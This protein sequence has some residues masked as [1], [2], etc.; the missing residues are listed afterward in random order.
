MVLYLIGLGLDKKS[1]S[2]DALHVLKGCKMVYLEG[3]TVDFPY[4]MGGLREALEIDFMILQRGEVESEKLI[5]EA[6]K[7]DIALLVYGDAL[8]ATTHSSLLEQCKEQRVEFKVFPNASIFT[9]VAATGLSLYKFGKVSSLPDWKQ[10]THKPASFITYLKENKKIKAHSLLLIDIG[11]EFSRALA[12]IRE[13]SEKENFTLGEMA[14]L[15]M[16]GT[17]EQKIY[18][19]FFDKFV[20]VEVKQPYCIVIPSEMSENEKIFLEKFRI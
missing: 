17:R 14:V 6:K 13:A 2:A 8:S 12:Q 15:S 9:A 7:G 19:G 11:L 20:G 3:Y 4:S 1:I 16:A 18:F 10:H 5:L